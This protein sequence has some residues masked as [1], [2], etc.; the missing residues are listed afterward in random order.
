MLP[1]PAKS[2][3]MKGN[4]KKRRPAPISYRPPKAR[5]EEFDAL[6]SASGL[7]VN[8]FLTDAVFRN[9]R[10]KQ[11]D[12]ALLNRLIAEMA[13]SRDLLRELPIDDDE[14]L[15]A[16]LDRVLEAQLEIRNAILIYTGRKP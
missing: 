5:E 3:T 7:S 2:Q 6:V 12:L 11:A 14:E 8:A 10:Y 4:E 13:A 15:R 9:G 1:C 16:V